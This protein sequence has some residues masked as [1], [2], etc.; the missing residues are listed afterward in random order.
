MKTRNLFPVFLSCLILTSCEGSFWGSSEPDTRAIGSGFFRA[1]YNAEAWSSESGSPYIFGALANDWL[2]LSGQSVDTVGT[3]ITKKKISLYVYLPRTGTRTIGPETS[4]V[5]ASVIVSEGSSTR[6]FIS[7]ATNSGSLTF[8]QLDTY[9][10]STRGTFSVTLHE[11]GNL[12]NEKLT[13]TDGTFDMAF[14]GF[15]AE[16]D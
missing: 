11:N 14:Q 1:T 16:T 6:Y 9:H 3:V 2:H 8:T 15:S 13:I 12:S 7:A 4:N 5:Y 10:Q